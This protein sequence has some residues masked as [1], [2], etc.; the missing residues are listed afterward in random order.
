[1]SP[2]ADF[3]KYFQR[4]FNTPGGKKLFGDLERQADD[5]DRVIAARH[6]YVLQ[7]AEARRLVQEDLPELRAVCA[8]IDVDVEAARTALRQA[9]DRRQRAGWDAEAVLRRSIAERRAGETGLRTTADPRLT[10]ARSLLSEAHANWRHAA[11]ELTRKALVGEFMAAHYEDLNRDEVE[12]LRTRVERAI[13]VI[14]KLLFVPEPTEEQIVAAVTEAEAAA[15]PILA[16][17]RHFFA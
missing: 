2:V 17:V 7:I 9:E 11:A 6:Q 13:D 16:C 4:I 1:M 15:R 3:S 14:D 12:A 10:E 8:Q 5:K